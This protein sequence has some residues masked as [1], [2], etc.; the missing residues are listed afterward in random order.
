MNERTMQMFHVI[1]W[2]LQCPFINQWGPN[3]IKQYLEVTLGRV[4]RFETL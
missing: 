2:M 1:D 3:K 4:H